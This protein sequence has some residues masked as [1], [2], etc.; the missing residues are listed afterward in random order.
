MKKHTF[1]TEF[2][3]LLG[4]L[5]LALGTSLMV[6]GDFGISMVVAPAYVLHAKLSAYWPFFTFGM[7][8][9]ALQALI[10]AV[11]LIV[12]RKRKWTWLLSFV[13]T[14]LYGLILDGGSYLT[15]L[16]PQSLAL[17]IGL[18]L[19]GVLLC[20]AAIALLFHAY[21]PPAAYELLVKVLSERFGW[22][23][24]TVKTLYD[25]AS[26]LTAVGMS[27]LLLGKLE[28]VGIGTVLCALFYGLL[29]RLWSRLMEKAWVFRDGLPL[30]RYFEERKESNEQKV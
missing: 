3:Y 5:V 8:E 19:V 1:Y 30:R 4:V 27:F 2:A 22:K 26:C 28:G 21:F 17:R 7:A 14:V 20:T 29:I 18:Y 16:L 10:L 25:C 13:T 12:F 6:Y 9:Y 23:L 11:M 15:T 24:H